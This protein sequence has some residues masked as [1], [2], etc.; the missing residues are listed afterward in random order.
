M[1]DQEKDPAL[2]MEA[3]PRLRMA[4]H[5]RHKLTVDLHIQLL[6][7]LAHAL[8]WRYRFAY[9]MM[10]LDEGI[11]AL[12]AGMELADPHP[13][14]QVALLHQLASAYLLR[15]RDN[16][17]PI[18]QAVELLRRAL[19]LLPPE[20][21]E[22]VFIATRL[23]ETLRI[24]HERTGEAEPLDQAVDALREAATGLHARNGDY[25]RVHAGLGSAYLARYRQAIRGRSAPPRAELRAQIFALRTG[26]FVPGR[27]AAE[28]LVA[29]VGSL[30]AAFQVARTYDVAAAYA[31]ALSAYAEITGSWLERIRARGMFHTACR[32]G[33]PELV[34]EASATWGE[35]ALRRRA[36]R[37]ARR[38]YGHGLAVAHR[39]FQ[40]QAGRT[41]REDALRGARPLA[42]GAAYASAR[43]DRLAEA[44]EL[45]EEGRAR[46]LADVLWSEDE[47]PRRLEREHPE[48]AA[49][50]RAAL[51]GANAAR[52]SAEL[53][54]EMLKLVK[55]AGA[56]GELTES[57]ESMRADLDEVLTEIRRLPGFA[58]F[59][60]PLGIKE[61]AQAAAGAPLV[62]LAA[63][64][65]GGMALMVEESGRVT[66]AWL[67]ALTDAE[68]HTRVGTAYLAAYQRWRRAEDAFAQARRAGSPL[69]ENR[70]AEM[71]DAH[72]RWCE[73]LD[74]VTRWAWDSLM[75]PLLQMLER[76]QFHRAVL[77]P[78]GLLQV[79]PL[80]AAWRE[81]P[82]AADG[83]CFAMEQVLLTYAPSARS[84]RLRRP[85]PLAEGDPILLIDDPR[86]DLEHS[87]GAMILRLARFTP[88][89]TTKLHGDEAN[90]ERVARALPGARL[91]HFAAHG[92]ADADHPMSSRLELSGSSLTL[93]DLLKMQLAGDPLVFLSACET[94]FPGTALP[95]EVISLSTGFLQ[96]GAAEVIGTLWLVNDEAARAVALEF[97]R[98]WRV[99]GFPPADALRHA[100]LA[101]RHDPSFAEPLF[102]SAFTFTGAPG[103][104]A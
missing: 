52:H 49:R 3:I 97:Y 99:E 19:A 59:A 41:H 96:A 13:G 32:G 78:H 34:L 22:R 79:L 4:M 92:L 15:A 69:A 18:R 42:T 75:G 28:N 36:W 12:E 77:I 55:K 74:V 33:M 85:Q 65:A 38:A 87:E 7:E 31:P 8:F 94:T 103:P 73:A 61:I 16:A 68:V 83:R 43:V 40:R 37:E 20:P 89:L 86:Q 47:L 88:A 71:V 1:F 101:L 50:L 98:A 46:L 25:V 62:Y 56:F 24:L 39:L 21:G 2:L 57:T 95:D 17:E 67:D 35:W 70:W 81:A 29:A 48:L 44:V 104:A 102:W 11:A 76:R 51:A 30:D 63:T 66:P 9:Q 53:F 93:Q 80:H 5:A 54:P 91:I 60:T 10:D 100:Q 6:R 84:L 72:E 64:P 58:A 26:N 45:L 23:G 82:D 27:G 14:E 90:W